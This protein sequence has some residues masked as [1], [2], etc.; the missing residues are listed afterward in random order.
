MT[1][2]RK[3]S[4]D[5]VQT[6]KDMLNVALS[7]DGRRVAFAM[8]S[9]DQQENARHNAIWLL[10]LDEQGQATGEPRQLTS[11]TKSDSNPVWAPDSRRLLFLSTREGDQNQLWLIDV[12]GGEARRLTDMLHGVSDVA[13]SPDG[14]WIAFTAP[15]ATTDDDEVLT[16][17]KKL[18]SDEKKKRE[19]EERI[20]LRTISRV[21][22]R[23]DG[24]GI[25]ERYSQ[26]FVMPAPT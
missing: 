17:Q 24:Q 4:F 12:A 6:F 2:P 23:L 13:W 21:F 7:P 1:V 9:L 5:D 18:N 16:G 26:L 8:S 14:Q 22:Y 19:D 25:F 11:G 15:A 20:R 10:Q 3:M